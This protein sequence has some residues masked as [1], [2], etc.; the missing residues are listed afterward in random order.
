MPEP[1]RHIPTKTFLNDLQEPPIHPPSNR[2]RNLKA[3]ERPLP[4][5]HSALPAEESLTAALTL[6]LLI[7]DH[8]AEAH[9]T[10]RDSLI[11]AADLL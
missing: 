10:F 5:K 11:R 1:F 7:C 9:R 2:Q 3:E 8:R 4:W 6:I